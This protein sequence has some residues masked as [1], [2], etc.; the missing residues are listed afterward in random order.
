MREEKQFY[1]QES[2]TQIIWLFFPHQVWHKGEY[3][4]K[5]EETI[6]RGEFTFTFTLSRSY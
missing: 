6:E 3:F 4:K 2:S 1:S 5:I